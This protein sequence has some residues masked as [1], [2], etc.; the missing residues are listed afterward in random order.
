[1]IAD[2]NGKAYD[3]ASN[4]LDD[5]PEHS[6]V[7]AL[8][9]WPDGVHSQA[10][11]VFIGYAPAGWSISQATKHRQGYPWGATHFR[12][13]EINNPEAVANWMIDQYK[14]KF[15]SKPVGNEEPTTA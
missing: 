13:E 3:F 7:F 12:R 4:Q 10:G 8:Y 9:N 15:S 5:C 1:M 14:I 11:C 6:F 2:L